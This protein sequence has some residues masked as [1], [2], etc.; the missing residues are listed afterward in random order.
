MVAYLKALFREAKKLD[1]ISHSEYV[2]SLLADH[3]RARE[4]GN[5][6]AAASF[7]R[8]IGQAIGSLSEHLR[9]EH[10]L[11][12]DEQLLAQIGNVDPVLKE[13]LERLLGARK[14]F[15]A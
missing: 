2:D 7:Q 11:P 9:V 13:R 4:A 10:E 1:L 15:D 14:E 12:S 6:T 5:W 8:L 3:A